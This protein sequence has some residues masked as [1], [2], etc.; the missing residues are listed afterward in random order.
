M[1]EKYTDTKLKQALVKM[2]PEKLSFGTWRTFAGTELNSELRWKPKIRGVVGNTVLDTELLHLCWLVEEALSAKEK[3]DYM[4]YFWDNQDDIFISRFG[5]HH[6][7][8]QQ[9]AIALIQVLKPNL[10]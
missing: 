7:T 2:L 5:V 1:S 6:A 8:W 9:R 10:A 4:I 3:S